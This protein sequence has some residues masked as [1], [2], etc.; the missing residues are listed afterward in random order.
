MITGT[1]NGIIRIILVFYEDFFFTYN[2]LKTVN[3]DEREG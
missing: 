2:R 3:G 1:V